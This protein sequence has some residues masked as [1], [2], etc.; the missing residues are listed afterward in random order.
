ML[1]LRH[2][3]YSLIK[4]MKRDLLSYEN[5]RPRFKTTQLVLTRHASRY[6]P[7]F[8]KADERRTKAQP[9]GALLQLIDVG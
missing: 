5:Q 6:S 8:V 9:S 4:N 1:L 3:L 7:V 2:L